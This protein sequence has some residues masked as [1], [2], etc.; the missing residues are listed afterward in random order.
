MTIIRCTYLGQACP[1]LAAPRNGAL[2]CDNWLYGSFCRMFCNS[3]HDV[4]RAQGTVAS[5]LFVCSITDGSWSASVPDCTRM[6]Y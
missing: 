4:S 6:Y 2:V 1:A 3:Q 5:R